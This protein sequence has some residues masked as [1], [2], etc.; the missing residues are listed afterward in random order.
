MLQETLR[1]RHTIELRLSGCEL[2]DSGELVTFGHLEAV[3]LS[4]VPTE[5]GLQITK[6]LVDSLPEI[7]VS[8]TFTFFK[9]SG[10][11]EVSFAGV[12]DLWFLNPARFISD[13]KATFAEGLNLWLLGPMWLGPSL[14]VRACEGLGLWSR[15]DRIDTD[16][17]N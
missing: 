4:A 10:F 9:R 3:H 13:L 14:K 11:K 6:V 7:A 8:T 12:F 17:S 5:L 15:K 1:R 16:K 2:E